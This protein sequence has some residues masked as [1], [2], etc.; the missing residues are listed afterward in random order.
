MKLNIATFKNTFAF[1]MW[2]YCVS[3]AIDCVPIW[4]EGFQ[5]NL[6]HLSLE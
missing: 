2:R 5:G 6:M 1:L 3:C 4:L